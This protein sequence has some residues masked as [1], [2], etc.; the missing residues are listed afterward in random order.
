MTRSVPIWFYIAEDQMPDER[1]IG[2]GVN[3]LPSNAS[4]ARNWTLQTY[5]HVRNTIPEVRLCHSLPEQGVLL[6]FRGSVSFDYRP[7]PRLLW[8]CIVADASSH[9]YAHIHIVQ[10]PAQVAVMANAFYIPHWPEL[11]LL[12]RLADRGARFENIDYFGD[13]AN[14]APELRGLGWR[15]R[16]RS[17]GLNW[18]VRPAEKWQDYSETD[19]VVAVRSFD[20]RTYDSKP[21]TKLFNGWRA[22]VPII[23][24]RESAYRFH[25]QPGRD[26]IEVVSPQDAADAIGQLKN[27]SAFRRQIIENGLRRATSLTPNDFITRWS[28]FFQTIAFPAYE[29]LLQQSYWWR[30]TFLAQRYTAVRIAGLRARFKRL[31]CAFVA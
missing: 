5:L 22:G 24:G 14:L 19:A 17:L 9:P 3:A 8:V 4:T 12:P 7:P 20:S 18:R 16:L 11:S 21:A 10:N 30:A 26:F 6:A 28:H 2:M 25:G 1:G 15:A 27:D 23:L 13:V 29:R 31:P